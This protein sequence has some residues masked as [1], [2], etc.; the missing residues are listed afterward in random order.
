MKR[1][2]ETVASVTTDSVGLHLKIW[3]WISVLQSA[4]IRE[5]AEIRA[6]EGKDKLEPPG[7]L[8]V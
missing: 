5:R 3:C 6:G 4:E 1:Y 8:C 7:Y 2:L